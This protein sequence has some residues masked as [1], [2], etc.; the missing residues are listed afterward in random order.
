[1]DRHFDDSG[2]TTLTTDFSY[3]EVDER[4]GYPTIEPD[5]DAILECQRRVWDWVYQENKDLDGFMCR[6]IVACWIFVPTNRA[7][8]MTYIAGRFGKKKQSLGR[9][10]DNFKLTFPEISKHLQHLRYE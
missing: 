7:Q 4:L 6:C 2:S 5:Y 3:A 1:M 10:V 9:W 8:T